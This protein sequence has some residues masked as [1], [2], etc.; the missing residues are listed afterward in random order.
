M[1]ANLLLPLLVSLTWPAT[2]FAE[3]VQ[4]SKPKVVAV[5]LGKAG[6]TATLNKRTKYDRLDTISAR[7]DS[8]GLKYTVMLTDCVSGKNC[9]SVRFSSPSIYGIPEERIPTLAALL[10]EWN[11][12]HPLTN[13]SISFGSPSL[14]MNVKT[15]NAGISEAD[16]ASQVSYWDKS[17]TEFIGKFDDK[18]L[19]KS[20][21]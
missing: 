12:G 4:A 19:K 3:P 18:E 1:R 8:S 13:A 21:L 16:F 2:V 9:I 15:G 7:S 14:E 10:N 17:L 11:R 20:A 6:Q 5:A